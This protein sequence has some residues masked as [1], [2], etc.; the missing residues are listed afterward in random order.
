MEKKNKP[1]PY[2]QLIPATIFLAFN[3]VIYLYVISVNAPTLNLIKP[4][5]KDISFLL[6][7][8]SYIST[9]IAMLLT[10]TSYF[11]I[12]AYIKRSGDESQNQPVNIRV[13]EKLLKKQPVNNHTEEKIPKKVSDKGG[14][15]KNIFKR[16][17]KPVTEDKLKPVSVQKQVPQLVEKIE[18]T[19]PLKEEALV[20]ASNAKIVKPNWKKIEVKIPDESTDKTT[21]KKDDKTPTETTNEKM[22]NVNANIVVDKAEKIITPIKEV[23][24]KSLE[25]SNDK[26]EIPTS[27]KIQGS[28]IISSAQHQQEIAPIS[29]NATNNIIDS[30]LSDINKQ[31]PTPDKNDPD[32]DNMDREVIKTLEELKQMVEEMKNKIKTK[33]SIN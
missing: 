28:N 10:L 24:V 17:K 11:S 8:G 5:L 30:Y 6:I 33:Q 4:G 21:N 18:K 14:F 20:D 3:L 23:D 16:E 13:E 15:F 2:R 1:K 31:E 9:A 25:V 27:P 22:E 7:M 32:T 26:K 29:T 19:P 12:K